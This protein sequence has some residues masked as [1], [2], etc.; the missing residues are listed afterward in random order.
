M[1]H[2]DSNIPNIFHSAFVSETLRIARS[3]QHFFDFLQKV[4]ELISRILRQGGKVKK[5]SFIIKKNINKD[6]EDFSKF[7]NYP[8][9]LIRQILILITSYLFISVSTKLFYFFLRQIG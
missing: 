1:S 3:T 4:R 8:N 5:M 7:G 6:Q 9:Y 2:I